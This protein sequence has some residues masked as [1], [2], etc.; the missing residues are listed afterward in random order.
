MA[1]LF[2]LKKIALNLALKAKKIE[3]KGKINE[4]FFSKVRG[5]LFSEIA[6]RRVNSR[7]RLKILFRFVFY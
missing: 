5:Y 4:L 3:I 2:L 6:N 1:S 7:M